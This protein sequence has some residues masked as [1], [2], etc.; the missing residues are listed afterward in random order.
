MEIIFDLVEG[1]A[2]F[3]LN[4]AKTKMK[5]LNQLTRYSKYEGCLDK[6]V[7]I[8]FCVCKNFPLGTP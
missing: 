6:R 3:K 2:T 1:P 7:S 8:E 4:A 5:S